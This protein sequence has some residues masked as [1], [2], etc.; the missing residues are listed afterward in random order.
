MNL[1]KKIA[2]FLALI[3]LATSLLSCTEGCVEAET[4]LK[5][6]SKSM[7]L[8]ISCVIIKIK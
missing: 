6:E 2:H 7:W 5:G 1:P 3:F 4:V 8:F